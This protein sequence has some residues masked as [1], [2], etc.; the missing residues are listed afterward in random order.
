M[1]PTEILVL[2]TADV[3]AFT[4]IW[5]LR[6]AHSNEARQLQFFDQYDKQ[7][8]TVNEHHELFWDVASF[9]R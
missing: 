4:L 5:F 3:I 2:F 6:A 8:S 1:T 9:F 7:V